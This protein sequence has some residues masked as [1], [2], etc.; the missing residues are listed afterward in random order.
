MKLSELLAGLPSTR[1]RQARRPGP[2]G[3]LPDLPHGLHP[4]LE[5]T[6]IQNV[7][8]KVEA[9]GMFVAVK[10]HVFDGHRFIGEALRRGAS[11]VV[12]QEDLPGDLPVPDPGADTAFVGVADTRKALAALSAGFFGRPSEKL[13]LIGVTGTN[14][15]TTTSFLI[16]KVLEAAG[17]RVGVIGT[18]NARY[19]GTVLNN[20]VTT[21]ESID[22]QRL[23][24]EMVGAGVTHVVMEVSSHA[25]D[26]H[27]VDHCAFDG[28]VFTNLTQDHL[29]YHGDME[30]YWASKRRLFT[31]HLA[32]GVKRERAWAVLNGEDPRGRELDRLLAIPRLRVGRTAQH[33]VHPEGVRL[34]PEGTTARIVTPAGAFDL[35]SPLVGA[36]NLEN[37]LSAAAA[38]VLLKL[39][40]E[41]IRRGL[42]AV[43]AIPGRL[44]RVPDPDGRHV[45]VDYAHT[46][47]ALLNVISALKRVGGNRSRL[48]CL[49]GCGGDRDRGKR[50][51]MGEIAG[52]LCDIAL[53]TSDNPRTENPADILSM[54]LAGVRKT[55]AVPL[56]PER[57]AG[58]TSEKGFLVE[59][60][61]KKAIRLG[62][63]LTR[64]GDTLL[65]A[66]KGHETYQ[67]VGSRTVPFDDRLEALGAME[68]LRRNSGKR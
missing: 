54:I 39:P 12:H 62:I 48:I 6:S 21:P 55:A 22:L 40:P 47:D 37:L 42:E 43:S 59:P 32:R 64:P 16:E 24:A 15:K 61:R 17:F 63:R 13:T 8:Q 41:R 53:L 57:T 56:D 49:F 5:I 46:P 65:I 7:A 66:G 2:G 51:L 25:L 26:L 45:Y 33:P 20:P 38:G 31:E 44:E 58:E 60:D 52:R 30:A 68:E 67:I 19:P 28:A 1:I 36:H 3:I 10:G 50:P 11:A 27:R 35:H 29:D 18:L 14:G 34:G 23:L 4:D 9:G